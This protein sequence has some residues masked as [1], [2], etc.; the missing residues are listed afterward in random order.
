MAIVVRPDMGEE[1]LRQLLKE[2]H[3]SEILDYKSSCDI[4]K[5]VELVELVKDIGATDSYERLFEQASFRSKIKRYLPEPFDVRCA[6]H[7]LNIGSFILIY[8]AKHPDGF[9]IFQCDGNPDN[10]NIVFRMG[11]VYARH[12][13]ASEPWNQHDIKRIIKHLV[14]QEKESWRG[15]LAVEFDESSISFNV[16]AR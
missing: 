2:G 11:Q 8:V 15:E 6:F 3:E 10:T 5:K 7:K 14:T 9:V 1:N 13:T 12:G 4:S 16:A